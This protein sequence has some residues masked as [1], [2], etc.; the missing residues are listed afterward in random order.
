MLPV[1]LQLMNR[2]KRSTRSNVKRQLHHLITMVKKSLWF[3]E[4]AS[5]LIV[6]PPGTNYHS[7]WKTAN[8]VLPASLQTGSAKQTVSTGSK[9]HNLQG[10]FVFIYCYVPAIAKVTSE[11]LPKAGGRTAT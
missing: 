9:S 10:T 7:H 8:P 11:T 6:K 4:K 1:L 5:S 2:G 3:T